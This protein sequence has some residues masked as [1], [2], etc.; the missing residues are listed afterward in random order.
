MTSL[1][2]ER[3]SIFTNARVYLVTSRTMSPNHTT[4]EIISAAL[5]AGIRLIQLREKNLDEQNLL[6][7]A[8]EARSLT[9]RANALLI[10][11][12]NLEIAL[13]SN[14]DGVHLGRDDL[15]LAKARQ[16]APDLIIGAS[17]HSVAEAVQAQ[18]QGASYINI[19]PVFPTQTKTWTSEFLGLQGI[20]EISQAVSIPFTVMGGIKKEHIPSLIAAG[21]HTIAVITAIT[22]DDDPK[23]AAHELLTLMRPE[24][25]KV[26]GQ[27]SKD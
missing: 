22:A 8:K 25:S 3:M 13:A 11:N 2:D 9:S 15:P 23:S 26:Q 14:A 19:G 10:I 7:L 1:H 20:K 6:A 5:S 18:Q 12:D 17:T 27:K 24:E 4:P 16:Q 21:T